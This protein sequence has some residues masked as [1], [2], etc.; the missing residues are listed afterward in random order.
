MEKVIQLQGI[1]RV[2]ATEA[3]NIRAGTVLVWNQ[4]VKAKVLDVKPRGKKQLVIKEEYQSGI[5]ERVVSRSR[6]VAFATL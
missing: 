2:Q 3:E 1:G 5:Y 6:L 4:G